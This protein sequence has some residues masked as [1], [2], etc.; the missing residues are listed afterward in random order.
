MSHWFDLDELDP[1]LIK[2]AVVIAM[3]YLKLK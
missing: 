1:E 3:S 2:F